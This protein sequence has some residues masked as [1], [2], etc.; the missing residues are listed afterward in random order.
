[1]GHDIPN[2]KSYKCEHMPMNGGCLYLYSMAKELVGG[3]F[4]V[5]SFPGLH[6]YVLWFV[7]SIAHENEAGL[8]T[9]LARFNVHSLSSGVLSGVPPPV[10]KGL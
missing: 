7:I 6:I 1:M 5:A 10:G 8:A 3:R 2:T 9:R 4:V